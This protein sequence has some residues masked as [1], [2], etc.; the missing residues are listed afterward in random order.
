MVKPKI[1][2]LGKVL[3]KQDWQWSPYFKITPLK[4]ADVK[5]EISNFYS[6]VDKAIEEYEESLRKNLDNTK[7]SS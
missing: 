4:S 5:Q 2:E 1:S 3:T 7:P 6:A